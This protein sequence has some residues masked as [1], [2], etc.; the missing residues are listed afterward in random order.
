MCRVIALLGL[1]LLLLSPL[2]PATAQVG[3]M[4]GPASTSA[5][6][7]ASAPSPEE[8][9]APLR[10]LAEQQ[11]N[12]ARGFRQL[13]VELR[14]D[15]QGRT[16]A[17][18]VGLA[19]LYGVFH[20]AGPG[21]GKMI[22]ISYF[23][24]ERARLRDGLWMG[25]RIALTHVAAA[26]A[27]VLGLFLLFDGRPGP[28]FESAREIRLLAYAGMTALGLWFLVEAGERLRRGQTLDGCG[29]DH[30]PR[31]AAAE[32]PPSGAARWRGRLTGIL[33]GA[34]PCT[35][36]IIVLVFCASNGLWLAGLLMVTAIAVGMALTMT[37]L[38]LVTLIARNRISQWANR[39]PTQGLSRFFIG[40]AGPAFV[41]LGGVFLLAMTL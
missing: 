20:A 40:L 18:A 25:I 33:A 12:A 35:G 17:A 16:L 23:L 31:P 27:I 7:A 39:R 3:P 37:G 8:R 38:G 2:S 15:G 14:T 9:F 5:A 41:T 30:G 4:R 36:A 6:P 13:L 10:W 21:H 29:H 26:L 1:M 34:V 22:V 32:T 28:D 19:F 24:A 11:R